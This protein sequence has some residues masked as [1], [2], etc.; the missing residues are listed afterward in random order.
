[1]KPNTGI[2]V[3]Y[4]ILGVSHGKDICYPGFGGLKH[5]DKILKPKAYHANVN[6]QNGLKTLKFAQDTLTN[7]GE[8]A[9]TKI[10]EISPQND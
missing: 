7:I 6:M 4:M 1:M 2:I 3:L 5:I 9:S 10:Q 8:H